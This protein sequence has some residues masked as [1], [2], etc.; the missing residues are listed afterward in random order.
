MPKVFEWN[1]HKFFF[2]SNEG[3]PLEPAHIH[4]RR[5]ENTMKVWLTPELRVEDS[6][7][8]SSHE[9]RKILEVIE[10]RQDLFLEKWNEY[11][12]L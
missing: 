10:A 9:V 1:G 11:F 2:F 7:G 3:H 8:F 4:V 5:A 6:Y 12:N